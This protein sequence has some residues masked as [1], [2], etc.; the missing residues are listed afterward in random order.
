[1]STIS[2]KNVKLGDSPDPSK[3]FVISVPSVADGTLTIKRENGTN[4]LSIAADGVVAIPGGFGR[5]SFTPYVSGGTAAGVGTYTTQGGSYVR[6]GN[7]VFVELVLVWTAHTGTGNLVIRTPDIPPAASSVENAVP[8]TVYPHGVAS[9]AGNTIVGV[10]DPVSSSIMLYRYDGTNGAQTAVT[11][12]PTAISL[13]I[14]FTYI[15][16]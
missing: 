8:V 2:L 14:A 16:A 6:V 15:A 12:D 7:L 10:Y 3:N 11:M 13:R 5:Q 9:A 4:V 1:M